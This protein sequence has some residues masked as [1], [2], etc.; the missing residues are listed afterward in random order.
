[1]YEIVLQKYDNY[2]KQYQED[3]QAKDSFDKLNGKNLQDNPID[4]I[5]NES[6]CNWMKGKLNLFYTYEHKKKSK[7]V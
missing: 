3:Q 5:E 6:L 2:K 7:S 4:I 1:M